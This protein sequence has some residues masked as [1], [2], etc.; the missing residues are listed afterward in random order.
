MI[1]AFSTQCM[2]LF[3]FLKHYLQQCH[4]F[5]LDARRM[6]I[7]LTMLLVRVDCALILARGIPAPA[8]LLVMQ[9]TTRLCA[10]VQMALWCHLKLTADRVSVVKR[11]MFF[12][13]LCGTAKCV[14]MLVRVR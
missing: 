9:S 5:L 4:L 8:Q 10:H 11:M 2:C 3:F 7:V 12:S 1:T 6:M 14:G 13:W